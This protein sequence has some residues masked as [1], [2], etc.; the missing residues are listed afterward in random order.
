MEQK[1]TQALADFIVKSSYD[2]LPQKAVGVAKRHILDCIG[3]A[4]LATPEEI[5]KIAIKYGENI[6]GNPEATIWG[7]KIKVPAAQAALVNGTLSHA[8]DYDDYAQVWLG[9]PTVAILPPALAMAEKC[10]SSGKKCLLA[11]ILGVDLGGKLS[12]A[13]G[14]PHYRIGWHNTGTLGSV[15]AAIAGAKIL[16]LDV[17]KMRMALGIGASLASG[18]RE[19]FGS[20]TKPLHAGN[21]GRNGVVAAE[22]AQMGFTANENI[23]EAPFGFSRVFAGGK[24]YP[25]DKLIEGLNSSFEVVSSGMTIKPYPSCG[26][27]HPM[28]CAMLRLREEHRISP[29]EV[30]EIECRSVRLIPNILIQHHPHRGLEGKFSMEFCLSAALVDGKI[31]VGQFTDESVSRPIIQELISKAKFFHPADMPDE[32]FLPQEVAVK[33]KDGKEYSCQ[34]G[35]PEVPGSPQNPMTWEGQVDKFKNCTEA[36]LPGKKAD[37]IVEMVEHFEELS[38]VNELTRLLVSSS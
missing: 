28:I 10:N 14:E 38:N 26:G 33:L 37:E 18:L 21:A 13:V 34:V 12:A 1:V 35:F 20:M 24:E 31:G 7:G 15:G 17:P 29:S 2:Q 22:L 27:T 3:V 25:L 6:K 32:V 9:H 4:L 11:Y 5:G 36:V 8:L 23:L 16:G 19:N 30:A